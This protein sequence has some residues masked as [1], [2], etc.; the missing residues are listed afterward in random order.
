MKQAKNEIFIEGLL[1]ESDI[2]IGTSKKDNTKEYIRGELRILVNQKIDGVIV[3]SIIPVRMFANQLTNDGKPS[4]AYESI[5]KVK[6]EF[7]SAASVDGDLTKADAVRITG[8]SLNESLFVP[9]GSDKE[10]SFP[11]IQS[12]FINKISR[13]TMTPMTKFNVVAVI[14]SIKEEVIQSEPTGVLLVKCGIVQ[15]NDRLDFVEFKV[16]KDAAKN[17]IQTVYNKGDTVNL[18]GYINF[19]SKTEYIAEEQGFGD[20]ILTPKTTTLR[21]LIITT[22]SISPFDE[23]RAYSKEDLNV[24]LNDRAARIVKKKED[25]MTP[26]PT[27]AS[28]ATTPA[29]PNGF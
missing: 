16:L 26:A 8:G 15:Y 27:H 2:K 6:N 1:L 5:L 14:N 20:P 22:G 28:T 19:I 24:A 23:E 21:E 17:H 7:V 10:A 4:K 18:Q 25:S 29:T 11:E 12:N 9:R 13:D 3:E